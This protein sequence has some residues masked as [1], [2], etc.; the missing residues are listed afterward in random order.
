MT[1]ERKI[2]FHQLTPEFYQ[3]NIHLSETLFKY[4]QDKGRGYGILLVATKGYRFAIPLRSKMNIRHKHN[5]TTKIHAP[6]GT[7]VRHGL[8]YTKALII[9]EDRFIATRDFLLAEKNDYLKI[10]KSEHKIINEFEAFID[11]YIHAVHKNDENI[12][13]EYRYSTLQNY[14]VELGLQL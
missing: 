3:E 5:F 10:A 6:E 8:D 14:H 1:D 7:R 2:V 11:K 9:S 12:L 13:R 4:G